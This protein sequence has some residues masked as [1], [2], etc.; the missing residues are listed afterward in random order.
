MLSIRKTVALLLVVCIFGQTLAFGQTCP[1]WFRTLVES[2]RKKFGLPTDAEFVEDLYQ[3][4]LRASAKYGL[5]HLLI[6]SLILV[7]SEFRFVVGLAGEL[8]LV[9]MK[10]QTAV[11]L[12]QR[13]GLEEPPDGWVSLLWDY[14]LNVEYGALYLRYLLERS[15]GNL[16]RALELYNGG[17]MKTD[18]ANRIIKTYEEMMKYQNSHS[19]R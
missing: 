15:N 16:F 9:Q 13:Y 7:E 10:P 4:I 19:G 6:V 3:A 1:D 17:S 5:D 14:N 18:Y 2:T 8:G 12:A 11:F